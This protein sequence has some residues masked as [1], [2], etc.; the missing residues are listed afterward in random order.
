MKKGEKVGR[1]YEG[2]ENV[3]LEYSRVNKQGQGG[4]GILED[5]RRDRT[6]GNMDRGRQLGKT[7]I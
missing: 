6:H 2:D 1:D 5:I 7:K 3:L 4:V